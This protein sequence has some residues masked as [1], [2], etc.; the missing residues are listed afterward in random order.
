MRRGKR[1]RDGPAPDRRGVAL[2]QNRRMGSD[3]VFR[4]VDRLLRPKTLAIIGPS[5]S[6]RGGWAKS[7]YEN[8]EYCGFPAKLTGLSRLF[9]DQRGWM[10][11]L[12]INPPMVRAAGH[13]VGAVDGRLTERKP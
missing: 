13:G 11:E 2:K 1:H 12:E 7:I 5:D 3:E 10:S 4:G 9:I 6:R 8:L